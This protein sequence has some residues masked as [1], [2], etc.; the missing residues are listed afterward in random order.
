MF[1]IIF[2]APEEFVGL[3]DAGTTSGVF[4]FFWGGGE[5]LGGFHRTPGVVRI[6]NVP[7]MSFRW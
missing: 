2:G 3:I 4:I 6:L 5:V 7:T 1:G